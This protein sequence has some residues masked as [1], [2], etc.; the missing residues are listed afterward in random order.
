[1]EPVITVTDRNVP[2]WPRSCW[3]SLI[4]GIKH[5]L[6]WHEEILMANRLVKELPQLFNSPSHLTALADAQFMLQKPDGSV[7]S[8]RGSVVVRIMR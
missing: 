1:M 6:M 4:S 8:S 2:T 3:V 7:H 5:P